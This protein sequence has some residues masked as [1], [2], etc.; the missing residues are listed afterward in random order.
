MRHL[1]GRCQNRYR[2]EPEIRVNESNTENDKNIE[3]FRY[4]RVSLHPYVWQYQKNK[5]RIRMTWL[6][7]QNKTRTRLTWLYHKSRTRLTYILIMIQ[8]LWSQ[9]NIKQKPAPHWVVIRAIVWHVPT[10][11][12]C[13]GPKIK[14]KTIVWKI[15]NQNNFQG[16]KYRNQNYHMTFPNQAL[17]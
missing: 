6:Y 16:L 10:Q 14:N 3:H 11:F 13:P 2:T 17:K 8:S 12:N 5:S 9:I 1:K 7:L 4:F 15:P